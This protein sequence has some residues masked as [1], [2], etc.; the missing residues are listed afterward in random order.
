MFVDIYVYET[1]GKQQKKIC[2]AGARSFPALDNIVVFTHPISKY[3]QTSEVNSSIYHDSQK[4]DVDSPK[5]GDASA[6]ECRNRYCK[7]TCEVDR[8]D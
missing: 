4:S 7:L 1:F 5:Q 2:S 3:I 8:L 6:V